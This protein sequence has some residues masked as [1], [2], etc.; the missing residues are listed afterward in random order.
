MNYRF[1]NRPKTSPAVVEPNH[2]ID[3]E[4]GVSNEDRVE[5]KVCMYASMDDRLLN[6]LSSAE[7]RAR[8]SEGRVDTSEGH[9]YTEAKESIFEEHCSEECDILKIERPSRPS[10]PPEAELDLD[11]GRCSVMALDP[12]RRSISGW[13]TSGEITPMDLPKKFEMTPTPLTTPPQIPEVR[14]RHQSARVFVSPEC[15]ED[16]DHSEASHSLRNIRDLRQQYD[17][18]TSSTSQLPPLAP[19]TAYGDARVGV[20]SLEVTSSDRIP[21]LSLDPAWQRDRNVD[22]SL[23]LD[24]VNQP[25]DDITDDKQKV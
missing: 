7:M 22:L 3:A 2:V 13:T 21:D 18:I 25:D 1:E 5:A 10:P 17:Y 19:I 16:I 4:R 6:K 23:D 14:H 15:R 11:D 12:D 9:E 8:Q 24:G 20:A